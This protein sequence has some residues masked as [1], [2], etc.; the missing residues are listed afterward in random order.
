MNEEFL[1]RVGHQPA[2]ITSLPFVHTARRFYRSNCSMRTR[3]E[4]GPW[5]RKSSGLLQNLFESR[6]LEEE[7][8]VTR[9]P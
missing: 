6:N 8:V 2:L 1:V 3:D 5:R 7:E 4:E 9:S